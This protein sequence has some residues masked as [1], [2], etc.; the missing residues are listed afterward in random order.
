MK[1]AILIAVLVPAVAVAQPQITGTDW[2]ASDQDT[3]IIR[4]VNFGA[5]PSAIPLKFDTFEA[6]GNGVALKS[7]QP[8]WRGSGGGTDPNGP[9]RSYSNNYAHSGALS[10]W[11]NT[12]QP[13]LE[14]NYVDLPETDELFFSYWFRTAEVETDPFGSGGDAGIVKLCRANSSVTGGTLENPGSRYNGG[15]G[16]SLSTMLPYY[17]ADPAIT[18]DA[19]AGGIFTA[20][21]RVDVPW[22][23]W[24]RIDMYGKLGT[25]GNPD[26]IVW[27]WTVGHPQD[28]VHYG[29]VTRATDSSYMFDTVMLGLMA[30]H[31]QGYF[32]IYIDDIYIDNTQA[33][34]ELG[35][36]ADFASCKHREMQIPQEWT[37]DGT[38]IKIAVNAGTLDINGDV[39]LFVVD[40]DGVPSPGYKILFAA[41]SEGPGVPSKPVWD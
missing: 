34:V 5:K 20:D 24:C 17:G 23:E 28:Q 10:V 21:D 35:D 38:S 36:R 32:E 15:G 26:G 27:G 19:G 37:S 14:T 30:A 18:M 6:G 9:G 7:V 40:K 41:P 2:S 16:F 1:F 33:R 12:N 3:V 4:G 31:P 11:Y 22:N 13:E 8:E 29:I 39:W 25:Y